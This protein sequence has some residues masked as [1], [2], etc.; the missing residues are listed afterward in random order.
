MNT[1]ATASVMTNPMR[2][3]PL[4]LCFIKLLPLVPMDPPSADARADAL[5]L[6]TLVDAQPDQE[7][8]APQLP[9]RQHAPVSAVVAVVAIVAHHEIMTVRHHEVPF[10]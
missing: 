5:E 9:L 3:M 4:C 6:H 7:R 1:P 2:V 8:L 10:P